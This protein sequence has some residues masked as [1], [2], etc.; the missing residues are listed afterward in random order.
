M[1]HRENKIKVEITLSAI[2]II[3]DILNCR[4]IEQKD[5]I[6]EIGF[7]ENDFSALISK[8]SFLTTGSA[9]DIAYILGISSDFLLN[10]DRRYIANVKGNK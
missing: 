7:S 4:H 6:Q 9:R 3:E 1:L 5:F 10:A 8:K 2:D